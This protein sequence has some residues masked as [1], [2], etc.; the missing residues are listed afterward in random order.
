MAIA[1]SKE[2][3]QVIYGL[4]LFYS[5]ITLFL[6][7]NLVLHLANMLS[8]T[9]VVLGTYSISHW[10]AMYHSMLKLTLIT[11]FAMPLLTYCHWKKGLTFTQKHWFLTYLVLNFAA[12]WGITRFS[13]N[14][15]FGITGWGVALILAAVFAS[16]QGLGIMTL[17][18]YLK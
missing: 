4:R 12:I 13:Q 15:G 2:K 9:H 7:N 3:V 1:L 17:N 16:A 5:L 8:P 6:V 11:T 10:W 18:K 14:L